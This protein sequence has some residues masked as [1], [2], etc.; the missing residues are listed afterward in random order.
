[1]D[2]LTGSPYEHS[3]TQNMSCCS[4][5]GH[6]NKGITTMKKSECVEVSNGQRVLIGDMIKIFCNEIITILPDDNWSICGKCLA[7]LKVCFEFI[8]Q[9]K[10]C[11]VSLRNSTDEEVKQQQSY[12]AQNPD[13]K[14][15]TPKRPRFK[16]ILPKTLKPKD[17]I[18]DVPLNRK[19]SRIYRC[20]K[21]QE[22]FKSYKYLRVHEEVCSKSLSSHKSLQHTRQEFACCI[23][24]DKT[25]VSKGY[26]SRHIHDV[27]NHKYLHFYCGEC[28]Q[29]TVLPTEED[30]RSH[31]DECHTLKCNA[32]AGTDVHETLPDDDMDLEMHE[33]FLDEFLLAHTN[34]NSFQF[35]ECW[36]AL[37]LHLPDMLQGNSSNFSNNENPTEEFS[38]PKCLERFHKM[39]ML[40][41]HLIEIHKLPILVCHG[42]KKVFSTLNDYQEHKKIK[43]QQSSAAN[44][45]RCPYCKK[46]FLSTLNLKQHIRNIHATFKKHTCQLCDKQ[47]ATVDHLKKH[48]LSLHQNERKHICHVCSKRFTQLCH[49]KQHLAIHTTGKSVKCTE[50]PEKFWRNVDMRR[51]RE[52]QHSV[53]PI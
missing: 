41:K 42:C 22:T 37:D 44:P 21:C 9:I 25:F 52:K 2:P 40:L 10:R 45:I 26:L 53:R 5:C 29:L 16:P 43:C 1:M 13:E 4:F 11:T 33:E 27:H 31:I 49:L 14:L 19:S 51:H 34:E 15:T 6:T 48:V 32:D 46:E 39:P 20:L 50:C 23:C 36:E 8:Q 28:E 30:I 18:T 3:L 47:F 17:K 7:Q 12:P 35:S 24:K 38:C